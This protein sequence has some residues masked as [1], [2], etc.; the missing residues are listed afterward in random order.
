MLN[1]IKKEKPLEITSLALSTCLHLI[2]FPFGVA[3]THKKFKKIHFH[4]FL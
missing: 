3:V 4:K 1:E 2:V